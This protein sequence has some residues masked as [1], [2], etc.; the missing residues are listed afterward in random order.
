MKTGNCRRYKLKISKNGY[1]CIEADGEEV[2]HFISPDTKAGIPKLY[3]V[4][5]GSEVYYVGITSQSMSSRLR[6]GF[7]ATGE[8]GP[9]DP[10]GIIYPRLVG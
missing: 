1:Q 8:N 9:L 2:N 3:V 10:G 7:K 4:K 5:N 6:Y